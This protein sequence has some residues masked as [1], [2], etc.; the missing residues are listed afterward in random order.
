MMHGDLIQINCQRRIRLE[1]SLER[2]NALRK[3]LYLAIEN[4]NSEQIL[5]CSK[6]IDYEILKFYLHDISKKDLTNKS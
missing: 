2:L 5:F 4:N 1:F 6:Q 3:K